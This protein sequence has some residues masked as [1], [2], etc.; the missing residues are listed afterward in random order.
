LVLLDCK[1]VSLSD[2]LCCQFPLECPKCAA[3]SGMPYKAT[4]LPGAVAVELRCKDCEHEWQCL[5]QSMPALTPKPD[6]RKTSRE[7]D[8]ADEEAMG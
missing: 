5:V 7:S 2:S 6:R 8:E 1:S 4:T 3:V